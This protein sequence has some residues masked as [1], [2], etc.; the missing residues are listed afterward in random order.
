MK[1]KPS[2]FNYYVFL[3]V[4]LNNRNSY[5][6]IVHVMIEVSNRQIYLINYLK[7]N[8]NNYQLSNS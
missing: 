2:T 8:V 7:L 1:D 3:N 5:L 4:S 6:A